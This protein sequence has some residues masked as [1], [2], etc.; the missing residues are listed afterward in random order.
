M[1]ARFLRW[2]NLRKVWPGDWGPC[3]LQ[4]LRDRDLFRADV[5][6]FRTRVKW[7]LDWE[8]RLA[9]VQPKVVLLATVGIRWNLQLSFRSLVSLRIAVQQ[10]G[11]EDRAS[12]AHV[13]KGAA[14][15]RE[16]RT[17]EL[18]G[19]AS[20][21]TAVRR[22]GSCSVTSAVSGP[23]RGAGDD[24]DP[25]RRPTRLNPCRSSSPWRRG[26]NQKRPKNHYA[27]SRPALL[28]RGES[29]SM[30]KDNRRLSNLSTPAKPHISELP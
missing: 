23:D 9:D 21:S 4:V 25:W 3:P 26:E 5:Q 13:G 24:S 17:L 14:R 8:H 20:S 12:V 7:H 18:G 16:C 15:H 11:G 27:L 19:G 29:S 22:L 1:D 2:A 10:R 28:L 30:T 6:R